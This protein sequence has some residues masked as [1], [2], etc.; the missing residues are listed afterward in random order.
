MNKMKKSLIFEK[1]GFGVKK[2]PGRLTDEI[3]KIS[4]L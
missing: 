1:I 2:M 4:Y 3:D